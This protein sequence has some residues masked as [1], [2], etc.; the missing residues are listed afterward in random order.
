MLSY[1]NSRTGLKAEKLKK[2]NHHQIK[3][4][5]LFR[6]KGIPT[7]ERFREN[8]ISE[9]KV[10]TVMMMNCFCGMVDQR[11]AFGLTF[12]WDHCQSSSPSQISDTQ[13]AGFEPAQ[14]LGSGL[15]D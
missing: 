13:Q 3:R 15:V 9:K 12:S 4:K 10:K 1:L 8:V 14:N 6:F 5:C 11:K 7:K 2:I